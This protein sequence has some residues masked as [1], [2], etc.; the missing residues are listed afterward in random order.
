VVFCP[1][2]PI[3]ADRISKYG[4]I[5]VEGAA[6]NRKRASTKSLEPLFAVLIPEV[7]STIR[8]SSCKCVMDRVEVQ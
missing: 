2:A 7:E 6:R 3:I 4:T 8:S 5:T 1:T